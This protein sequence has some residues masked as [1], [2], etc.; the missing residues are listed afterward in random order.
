MTKIYHL[1][2]VKIVSPV[3]DNVSGHC[4]LIKENDKLILIDTGIGLLDIQKPEERIG[5][6]LI[7]MVGYRFNEN[8]TAIRQIEKLGLSPNEV[9]D[10]V[11]SHL[12]NDHIGGLA[13][14]P[15]A[16]VHV[17]IEEYENFNSGNPRYLK[18]PLSHNP[19]IT[20]Y[21]KSDIDWFGFEARKVNTNTE[22]EIFLIPLFGHTLGH[23]G[24]AIKTDNKWL[25]YIA[26][27][28]YM[29]IELT[30]S[31]HP[32]NQL[33]RMR[34]EDNDLRLETLDKIRNLITEHPEIEV[35]GYHDIEEFKLYEN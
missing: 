32:V 30:D 18:I 15:N 27:A 5:Q 28:Y 21:K 4:L 35:F 1:N 6:Q 8:Q 34:A 9:T 22:T 7:D 29:R 26:D 12:D 3:N 23:C 31:N 10:C 14:F 20:T 17:G 2:C 25:F 16:I 11:I 19:T 24:V 13:D 33:A